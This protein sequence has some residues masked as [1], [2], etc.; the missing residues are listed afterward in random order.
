VAVPWNNPSESDG[1]QS[2]ETALTELSCDGKQPAAMVDEA[3]EVVRTCCNVCTSRGHRVSSADDGDV[4]FNSSCERL[5]LEP[6]S[7]ITPTQI[8]VKLT[9]SGCHCHSGAVN[10]T[11]VSD[12]AAAHCNEGYISS[13]RGDNHIDAA[14]ALMQPVY[15]QTSG[16]ASVDGW[17]APESPIEMSSYSVCRNDNHLIVEDLEYSGGEG[18]VS[19]LVPSNGG[20]GHRSVEVREAWPDTK[21]VPSTGQPID[22]TDEKQP[23]LQ[24]WM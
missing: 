19:T 7:S 8:G 5:I 13:E 6:P 21:H 11:F 1:H 22:V 15:N 23:P 2:A 18:V 16:T 20:I 17:T 24:V 14:Q 10:L 12:D 9:D 3:S 4:L